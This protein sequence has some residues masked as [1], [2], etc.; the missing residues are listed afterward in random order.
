VECRRSYF[1]RAA[2]S[3]S[4]ALGLVEV[5]HVKQSFEARSYRHPRVYNKSG[6]RD[7]F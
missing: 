6:K 3:F 2:L 5:D 4:G 1:L 7:R